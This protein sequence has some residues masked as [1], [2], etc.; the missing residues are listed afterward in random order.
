MIGMDEPT[1]PGPTGATRVTGAEP[2]PTAVPPLAARLIAFVAILVAGAA[3]AFIGW[4]FV[5]LQCE[6]DCGTAEAVGAL[7]GAV[8]A[9]GGVGV[10]TVL[11]LRAMNEWRTIQSR[12]GAGPTD[13]RRRP[14]P[15]VSR[16]RPRVR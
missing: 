12:D 16:P 9:A 6:G 7:V 10:V 8:I 5:D 11:A 14:D 3:G 2:A 4:A 13:D 1:S 15:R